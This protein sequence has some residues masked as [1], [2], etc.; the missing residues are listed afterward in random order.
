MN[1]K[2][3]LNN[4]S[5]AQKIS[6]KVARIWTKVEHHRGTLKTTGTLGSIHE[7]VPVP[8]SKS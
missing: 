6:S 3:T 4:D 8:F 1:I 2:I 5:A 7:P